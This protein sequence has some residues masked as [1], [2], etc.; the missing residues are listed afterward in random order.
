MIEH[1]KEQRVPHGL[2]GKGRR[3]VKDYCENPGCE[4]P[5]AKVVPV[6]VAQPSDETRTLCV[7]CE[8]AYTWG[9]Q[10]ATMVA[11]GTLGAVGRQ[12]RA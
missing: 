2:V 4:N 8:E 10:H 1:W 5:G 7:A 11:Q 6:S 3:C 12:T 9:V